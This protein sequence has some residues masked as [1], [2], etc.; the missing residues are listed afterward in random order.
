MHTD[1]CQQPNNISERADE[2]RGVGK[3]MGNGFWPTLSWRVACWQCGQ[4]ISAIVLLYR[5]PSPAQ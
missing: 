4:R 2:E 5:T 1:R 3:V